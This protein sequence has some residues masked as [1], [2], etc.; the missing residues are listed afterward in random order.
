MGAI[1]DAS[2]AAAPPPCCNDSS[3][4]PSSRAVTLRALRFE[5]TPHVVLAGTV[6]EAADMVASGL[7][8]ESESE[9]VSEGVRG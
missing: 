7:E 3:E 6:A 4:L 9:G 5:A 1:T 2:S 8:S